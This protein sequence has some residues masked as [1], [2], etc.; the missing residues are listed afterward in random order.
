MKET[1]KKL[2]VVSA[3]FAMMFADVLINKVIKLIIK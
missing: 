1:L 2:I 3:L